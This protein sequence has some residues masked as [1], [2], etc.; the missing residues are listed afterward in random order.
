M[1]NYRTPRTMAECSWQQGY[2]S[3]QI[4]P[5]SERFAGVILAVVIGVVLAALWAHWAAS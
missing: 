2:P 1:R 3:V 5:R 4:T